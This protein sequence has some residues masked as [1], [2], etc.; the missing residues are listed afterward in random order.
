M[1]S[2][3]RFSN[4]PDYAFPRLRALLA[5]IP[6]GGDP[7]VLTIGACIGFE[8]V[9]AKPVWS[10]VADGLVPRLNKENLFVAIGIVGATVMPHNLYLHSSLVKT[11]HIHG[12]ESAK[13]TAFGKTAQEISHRLGLFMSLP[14][15]SLDRM[16][17]LN[18][19]KALGEA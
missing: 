3:E 8:I 16:S 9:L 11:R 10:E 7:V 13:R 12:D 17:L 14:H 1:A 19:V 6:A 15:D 18:A 5:G 4:L 2:P